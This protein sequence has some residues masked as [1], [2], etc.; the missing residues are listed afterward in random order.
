MLLT[1]SSFRLA[2]VAASAAAA[3]GF[4]APR[5]VVPLLRGTRSAVAVRSASR[6]KVTFDLNPRRDG[7]GS[8]RSDSWFKRRF[9]RRMQTSKER[10]QTTMV[11]VVSVGI[12]TAGA[13]YAAVPLYRMF[14]QSSGYGGT[15]QAGHDPDKVEG[16]EMKRERVINVKFNA[17]TA[18]TMQWNFRPQQHTIQVHPGETALAFYT[19]INCLGF[20]PDLSR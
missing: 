17:D 10:S 16:M 4:S 5:A 18:A 15:T 14:C 9:N 3:A 13:S 20:F 12:L 8:G 19:V 1:V 11:Y 6:S 2:T 7:P